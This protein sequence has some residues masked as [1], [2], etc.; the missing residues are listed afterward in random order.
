[1]A[2]SPSQVQPAHPAGPDSPIIR[3]NHGEQAVKR[4]SSTAKH[5]KREFYCCKRP[6]GDPTR[7]DFW[8]WADDPLLKQ[9]ITP[10]STPQIGVLK[11]GFKS[12]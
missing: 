10:V 6:R 12:S 3:C 5:L 1:M 4:T 7:C 8:H 2:S 11:G 9:K